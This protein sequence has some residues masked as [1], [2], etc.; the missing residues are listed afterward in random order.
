MIS[1]PLLDVE[2]VLSD[3]ERVQPR[4]ASQLA[5]AAAEIFATAPGRTWVRLRELPED[6]Y[7]ENGM[8]QPGTVCPVFVSILKAER[9][10]DQQFQ[11]EIL[12]LTRAFARILGRPEENVHLLYLPPGK[13]RVSFGGKRVT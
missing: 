12:G 13:G 2:I 11:S 10:D 8:Q 4:W 5:D 9:P 1:M 7:A 6:Q 3:C